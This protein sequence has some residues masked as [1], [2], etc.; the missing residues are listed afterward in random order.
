MTEEEKRTAARKVQLDQEVVE[1]R[2]RFTYHAPRDEL[3]TMAHDQVRQSCFQLAR[4][5]WTLLPEGRERSLVMT[6][7]EE[8]AFWANAAIARSR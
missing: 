1:L 5:L 7:L 2:H 6:K 3:V 4:G 8:A